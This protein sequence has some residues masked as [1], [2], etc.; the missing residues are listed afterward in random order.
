[1]VF[2]WKSA[3]IVTVILMF[4]NELYVTFMNVYI[5]FFGSN[6]YFKTV[7]IV[8]DHFYFFNIGNRSSF[9]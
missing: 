3:I 2:I 6:T 5:L 4:G 7:L 9:F 8:D 1:M